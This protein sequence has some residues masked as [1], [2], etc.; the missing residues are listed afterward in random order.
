MYLYFRNQT[1]IVLRNILK[2]AVGTTVSALLS[3]VPRS[4][5]APPLAALLAAPSHRAV[6]LRGGSDATSS[7]RR[8]SAGSGAA[9][10]GRK[11]RG[12]RGTAGKGR[13][14]KRRG[15]GAVP[16]A[17]RGLAGGARL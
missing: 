8:R 7:G 14:G 6:A 11:E 10:M 16:A 5:S 17:G 15:A 12:E 3:F 4:P 9:A 2:H 1:R 13:E